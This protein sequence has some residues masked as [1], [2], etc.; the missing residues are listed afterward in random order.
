MFGHSLDSVDGLETKPEVEIGLI[1]IKGMWRRLSV[2]ARC[3][4]SRAPFV[5][6]VICNCLQDDCHCYARGGP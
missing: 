4:G 2:I 3:S 5:Q 6:N 1:E